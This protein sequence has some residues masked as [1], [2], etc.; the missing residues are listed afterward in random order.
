VFMKMTEEQKERAKATRAKTMAARRAAEREKAAEW[1][2]KQR[3]QEA[4]R[5][6]NWATH[7]WWGGVVL[8]AAAMTQEAHALECEVQALLIEGKVSEESEEFERARRARWDAGAAVHEVRGMMEPLLWGAL[9]MNLSAWSSSREE[10]IEEVV[11]HAVKARELMGDF[12]R[13]LVALLP[14][15]G[16]ADIERHRKRGFCVA[17]GCV[18][19][20]LVR[21][22]GESVGRFFVR[23]KAGDWTGVE[24]DGEM[25]HWWWNKARPD[26]VV[27]RGGLDSLGGKVPL[28]P[29]GPEPRAL[30]RN[31]AFLR[32]LARVFRWQGRVLR[33]AGDV[34]VAMAARQRLKALWVLGGPVERGAFPECD[35]QLIKRGGEAELELRSEMQP[36]IELGNEKSR[37][38][39]K[40]LCDY[41]PSRLTREIPAWFRVRA[42]RVHSKKGLGCPF[43]VHARYTAWKHEKWE[44][45]GEGWSGGVPPLF[46]LW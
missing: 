44:D 39:A 21:E 1:E 17:G 41:F 24:G 8:A 29:E 34:S 31:P 4:E 18:G 22:R 27:G 45:R 12:P 35:E 9:P 14:S 37:R 10:T 42:A 11:K 30:P 43:E 7:S 2:S 26:G 46:N 5:C 15:L 23:G 13:A 6:R 36:F 20:V 32:E 3:R 33:M 19:E 38:A 40:A 16:G 28:S 25:E